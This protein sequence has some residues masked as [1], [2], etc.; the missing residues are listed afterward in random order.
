MPRR[1]GNT[2]KRKGTETIVHLRARARCMTDWQLKH[3][4]WGLFKDNHR[5]RYRNGAY[6][7]I[8]ASMHSLNV[9]RGT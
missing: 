4:I 6:I 7:D 8:Y 5:G 1:D 3:N 9:A 2:D